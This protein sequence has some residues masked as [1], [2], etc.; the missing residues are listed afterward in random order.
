LPTSLPKVGNARAEE[1]SARV[2]E[3]TLKSCI[4]LEADFG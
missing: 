1:E 2:A 3:R 4:L